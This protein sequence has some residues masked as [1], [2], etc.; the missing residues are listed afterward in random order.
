MLHAEGPALHVHIWLHF[1]FEDV[2]SIFWAPEGLIATPQ[3]GT[4]TSTS[5]IICILKPGLKFK[6]RTCDTDTDTDIEI[7]I[8]IDID[9]ESESAK[10]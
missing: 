6:M 1:T 5:E 2:A 3:R 8:D 7:E 9:I 10:D 4:R